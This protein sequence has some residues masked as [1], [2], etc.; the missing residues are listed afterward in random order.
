[1]TV[2]IQ[3]NPTLDRCIETAA[4]Q[5]FAAI[6][7]EYVRA[8]ESDSELEGKIELVRWFLQ[9]ADFRELRSQSEIY[10]TRG[11][12]VRFILTSQGGEA[13]YRMKVGR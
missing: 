1:M 10:L 12:E 8:S 5:E 3:L 7:A 11:R 9:S 6:S 4:R 13:R 2:R